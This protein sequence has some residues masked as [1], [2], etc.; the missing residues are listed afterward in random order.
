MVVAIGV[1]WLGLFKASL[2][3]AL[4][5][6]PVVAFMP[7]ASKGAAKDA[8]H[9]ELDKCPPSPL[10]AFEH[11]V[12][13]FVQFVVLSLFGLCNVGVQLG[14]VGYPTLAVFASLVVGKTAGI[15]L[16]SVIGASLKF[17]LPRG[18]GWFDIVLLGFIASCGL[19]VSLFVA[20]EAFRGDPAVEAEA[21]MGALLSLLTAP[22]AIIASRLM[23]DRV[24]PAPRQTRQR[25]RR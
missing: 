3:P 25:S 18:V 17:P 8:D 24:S 6:V 21:K 1:A 15:Y 7:Q 10:H 14:S 12:H 5:L 13:L 2:H 4:A 9:A 20:G 22:L 16:C 11:D 19:T 23:K